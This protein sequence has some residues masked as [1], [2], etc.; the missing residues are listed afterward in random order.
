MNAGI[1]SKQD[2]TEARELLDMPDLHADQ[3]LQA[4]LEDAVRTDI[5]KM[6]EDGIYLAPTDTDD[7]TFAVDYANKVYH[8][9]RARGCPADRLA[10]LD[11]Y[12]SACKDMLTPPAAPQSPIQGQGATGPLPPPENPTEGQPGPQK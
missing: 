9:E 8:E 6:L 7:L 10:V 12:I 4:A 2:P 1:I 3:N 5:A 11:D